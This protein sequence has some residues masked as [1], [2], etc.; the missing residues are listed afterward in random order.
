MFVEKALSKMTSG[1]AVILIQENAGSGN[2][3]P[4]TK[5]LLENNTLLASI[6]MADIFHGKAG[7]QTAVYVFEVGKAHDTK[8]LVRFIDMTNDGY[9]RQN[10]KKSG[11]DVNLRNTDHA[12]ERYQ[13][14]VDL[15]NYGKK[16]LHYFTES[17]YIE[18]IITLD[19]KDWTFAQHK[20][21]ETIPTEA[22]FMKV[23]SEYL[24]WE[25]GQ[26]LRGECNAQ[27]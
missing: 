12:N 25:V 14:V 15:V 19:G 3:L 4:Y 17:D 21:I 1:R 7:V 10:R 2:G 8:Q 5:K 27:L 6:H 23:V 11:L 24:A 13:E 20:K 16:Y 18:D 26:V 9:S 22:D